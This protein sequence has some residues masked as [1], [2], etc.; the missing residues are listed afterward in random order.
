MNLIPLAC[1]DVICGNNM[2]LI[3]L[4]C[5]DMICQEQHEINSLGLQRCDM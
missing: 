1:K 2:N 4:A 3:P 5:K